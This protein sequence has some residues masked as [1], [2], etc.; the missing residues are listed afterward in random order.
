MERDATRVSAASAEALID[1]APMAIAMTDEKL[2]FL[3]HSPAWSRELNLGDG[4]ILGRAFA[5]VFPNSEAT[6]AGGLARA[7]AGT[8]ERVDSFWTTLSN[9]RRVCLRCEATPWRRPDGSIGGLLL[10]VLDLTS[11]QEALD[12]SR[13]VERRLKIA[14]EIA[15]VHVFEVDYATRT[16]TRDGAENTFFDD[17]PTFEMIAADPFCGV[18]EKDRERIMREVLEAADHG[19]THSSEYR[20]RRT[21][22]KEIWAF[23]AVDFD[24]GPDGQLSNAIF[25][26]QNVTR[27]KLAEQALIE[28]KEEAEAANSAKSVFLATMSHEIRTP[29]NGVLGMA[30]AMEADDLSPKQRER[31]ALVRQSGETLLAIL[32]DLLDLSKIE[33]GKLTLEDAE[34]DL[35]GLMRGAHGAFTARAE[36]KGLAF[37][38][39]I[40]PGALGVYKGDPVRVRQIVYNLLANAVKFTERGEVAMAVG[41]E[42]EALTVTVRDTGPG[43]SAEVQSRLFEKFEQADASTTRRYGGT[44]LGLAICRELASLMGGRIAARSVEGEGAV[45]SVTLPLPRV[46]LTA[47]GETPAAERGSP[48]GE[49]MAAIRVLAAEDNRVNQIVIATLLEQIGCEVVIAQNGAEAVELW[50][51]RAFDAILM[52]AQMPVMDGLEASRRIRLAERESGRPRTPIIALTADAMSHQIAAY[53]AAGMDGFVAKP[54]EVARLYE[55]LENALAERPAVGA[56]A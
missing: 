10:F 30:Q 49:T 4:D 56:A 38:L 48:G 12:R 43:I 34:F 2:I 29:L 1:V 6:F 32:N 26:L 36:E 19:R 28:A 20:V 9:G 16:V 5:E 39:D 35:G 3:R 50:R 41:R 24:L 7:L 33:A 27:R 15:D 51:S 40:E 11:T 55:A 21:D 25:A 52:D 37:R 18:H 46:A 31:L 14:T 17:P 8:P 45:F 22:D 54:I 47:S 23:S 42:G 13:S 44:G 53:E